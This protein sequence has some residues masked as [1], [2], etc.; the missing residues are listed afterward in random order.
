MKTKSCECDQETQRRK[1]VAGQKGL[2]CCGCGK[3]VP[4]EMDPQ[5]KLM[6]P[7]YDEPDWVVWG[8]AVLAAGIAVA[9]TAYAVWVRL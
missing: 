3:W 6:A 7:V 4:L 1:T 9:F 8:M 5:D 2:E